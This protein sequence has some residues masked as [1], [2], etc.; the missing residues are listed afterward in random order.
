MARD[1]NSSDLAADYDALVAQVS[2]LR[3]EMAK[4]A[5]QMAASASARG[6]AVAGT[7]SAG[8]HDA[9]AYAGRRAHE[10]D[11]RIE[12]AVA[13]NPYLALGLAAGLGL[14]LGVATRR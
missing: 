13:A 3:D 10:V 8:V 12:H 11:V 9:Q 1:P 14:L 7:V 6:A 4:M 2:A 5:T